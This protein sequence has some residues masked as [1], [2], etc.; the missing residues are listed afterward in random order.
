MDF[1]LITIACI[2]LLGGIIG[3]FIPVLPGPPLSWLGL[4]LLQ[5]TAAV[6][7]NYW[8]LGSTALIAVG[9]TALD[10]YLPALGTKKYGG[11]KKGVWGAILGLLFALVM[12]I[13]GPLGFL[14]WP[15]VGAFVGEM[16]HQKNQSKALK[17]ALGS[18]MGFLAGTLLKLI[19]SLAYTGLFAQ[20]LWRYRDAF[21]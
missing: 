17:A 3:S 12:P 14:V 20:Q 18:F 10:Y 13:L 11:S 1:L 15:F 8:F 21:F 2:C 9:A 6:P 16:S 4:L 5:C 7:L 19:I